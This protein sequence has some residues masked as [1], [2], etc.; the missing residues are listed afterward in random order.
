MIISAGL[1]I[2][3]V[4]GGY[5]KRWAGCCGATMSRRSSTSLLIR[6]KMTSSSGSW[7]T[8]RKWQTHFEQGGS[9]PCPK[10]EF[11]APESPRVKIIYQDGYTTR[12]S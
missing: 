10:R 8:W 7:Q 11:T 6:P 5:E 2:H 1:D 9:M 12:G 3:E 4:G